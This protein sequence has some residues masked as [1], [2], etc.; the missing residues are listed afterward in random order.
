MLLGTRTEE[1]DVGPK[2]T[3]IMSGVF[4]VFLNGFRPT[5]LHGTDTASAEAVAGKVSVVYVHVREV[6]L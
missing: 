5:L 1:Q 2:A 6:E 4:I 3:A